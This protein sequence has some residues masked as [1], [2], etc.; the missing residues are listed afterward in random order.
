MNAAIRGPTA[1]R[2]TYPL[3]LLTDV[4]RRVSID[5][6]DVHAIAAR[7]PTSAVAR[8]ARISAARDAGPLPPRL[9]GLSAIYG[10][11]AE[12]TARVVSASGSVRTF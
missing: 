1:V 8:H 11:P 7:R 5:E 3:C 12:C 4:H 6:H 2:V 10:T 9:Q